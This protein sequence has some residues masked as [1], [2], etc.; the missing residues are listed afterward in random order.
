MVRCGAA[1]SPRDRNPDSNSEFG[2]GLM[3]GACDSGRK[4]ETS[5]KSF[6]DSVYACPH[7]LGLR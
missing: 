4:M 1:E 6:R 7:R 5:A 2:N 3:T